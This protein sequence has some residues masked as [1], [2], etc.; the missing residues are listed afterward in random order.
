MTRRVK[1]RWRDIAEYDRPSAL[2]RLPTDDYLNAVANPFGGS[3]F[4]DAAQWYIDRS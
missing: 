2:D 1:A 3:D 4:H